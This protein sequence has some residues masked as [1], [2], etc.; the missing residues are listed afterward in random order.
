MAARNRPAGVSVLTSPAYRHQGRRR[1]G[2]NPEHGRCA[3]EPAWVASRA[4]VRYMKEITHRQMRNDSAEV[5]RHVAMGET[6][7]VTNNGRPAAVIGP[8]TADVLTVLASRGELREA[9][10]SPASLRSIKR[11]KSSRSTADLLA[12]TRSAW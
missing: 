8:P 1:A 2:T 7:L 11:T 12:S 6:I 5:L 10:Q 4:T 9:T 3:P